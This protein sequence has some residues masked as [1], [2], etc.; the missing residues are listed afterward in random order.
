MIQF[1]MRKLILTMFT[2]YLFFYNVLQSQKYFC[3]YHPRGLKEES[4]IV[5]NPTKLALTMFK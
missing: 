3:D 2:Y 4:R 1:K 5:P